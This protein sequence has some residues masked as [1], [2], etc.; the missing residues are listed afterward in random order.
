MS[1]WQMAPHP[2]LFLGF[3]SALSAL[4]AGE[5]L[6]IQP[7]FEVPPSQGL[8]HWTLG[9]LRE[10]AALVKC[11]AL[12][13]VLSHGSAHVRW[14]E[15]GQRPQPYSRKTHLLLDPVALGVATPDTASLFCCGHMSLFCRWSVCLCEVTDRPC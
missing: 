5:V 15:R 7:A 12:T 9:V 1:G 11:L 8:K 6:R 2:W 3:L 14:C 4:S 10:A 13:S